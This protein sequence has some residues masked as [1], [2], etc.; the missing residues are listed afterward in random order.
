M[1]ELVMGVLEDRLSLLA[2]LVLSEAG[3]TVKLLHPLL[4]S[5]EDG[6]KLGGLVG[7]EAETFAEVLGSL[8]GIHLAVAAMVSVL[9]GWLLGCGVA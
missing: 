8:L 7:G 3:V 4:L 5:G 9:A 2:A 6:L 1:R